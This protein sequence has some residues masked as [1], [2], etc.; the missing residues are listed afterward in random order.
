M[1][2][3]RLR[4]LLV[5]AGASLVIATACFFLGGIIAEAASASPIMGVT[6]KT[7]GALA[8][9]LISF[10]A[11]FYGYKNIN[12]TSLILK[13]AVTLQEGTFSKRDNLFSARMT[14]LKSISGAKATSDTEAIWEA[15]NLTVHLRDLEQ[16]DLVMIQVTD[17]K[18]GRWKSEFFSPFC[19]KI[20]L[21]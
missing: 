6:F 21:E 8:G 7:G 18:G 17:S 11:L 14:V 16:D 12:D 10:G 5:L 20:T 3:S 13:V 15:G 2:N 9:F 19:P 1:I 4:H